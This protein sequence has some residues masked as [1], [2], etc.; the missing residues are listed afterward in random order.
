MD[1]TDYCIRVQT[2][3]DRAK[4]ERY[5][6]E[7]ATCWQWYTDTGRASWAV[8]EAGMG[9]N[10]KARRIAEPLAKRYAKELRQV[11]LIE[12]AAQAEE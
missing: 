4:P 6:L 5:S 1:V 8:F 3:V 10:D 9:H 2:A 12:A 7:D 11:E